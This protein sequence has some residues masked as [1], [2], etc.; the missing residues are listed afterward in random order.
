MPSP[1][2]DVCKYDDAT[3]WCLGCGMTKAEKKA[4]KREEGLRGAILMPLTTRLA[5]M[6]ALGRTTGEAASKKKR[7]D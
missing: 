1:C 4:W 2:I 6:A 7:K 5:A 3:D